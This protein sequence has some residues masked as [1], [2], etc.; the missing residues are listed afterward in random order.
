MGK[1]TFKGRYYARRLRQGRVESGKWQ[2]RRNDSACS[3]LVSTTF[4]ATRPFFLV[5]REATG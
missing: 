4:L 5:P 1:R 3:W 2:G